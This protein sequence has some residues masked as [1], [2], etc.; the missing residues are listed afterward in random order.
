MHGQ[1]NESY[2]IPPGASIQ[3]GGG[4]LQIV[5]FG[6]KITGKRVSED[7]TSLRCRATYKNNRVTG[8]WFDVRHKHSSYRGSF[9]L[10]LEPDGMCAS[11]Q[12]IGFGKHGDIRNGDMT[13]KR[14]P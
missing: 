1:W 6:V 8:E 14:V 13:W 11:G 3:S 12:W 2:I 10:T 4:D 5:H 7:G 9:Q